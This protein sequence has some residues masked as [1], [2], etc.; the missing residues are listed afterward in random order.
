M[1]NLHGRERLGRALEPVGRGLARTGITPDAITVVG[2][3]GVSGGALGFF[4]R[5]S[6]FVGTLVVT[7]F[8]FSDMLD[9]ALARALGT[10]GPWGAFLDS[11]MDRI[12]DAAVFGSFVIWYAGRGHS[13]PLAGA[14]LASLAG[15]FVTS[16]AKARAESLGFTCNVGFA[17]RAER[18]II[19]LVAAGFYGLGVPYLL[20]VALWF[21]AGA[22]AVTAGQ[23]LVAVHRQATAT[24]EPT[25]TAPA[26]A[27]R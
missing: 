4:T 14:A 27:L 8:V 22:T 24:P 21:L 15:G 16:Y 23:R 2:T 10:S 12:G 13:L 6:F 3:I 1:L 5:G 25:P 26:S 7:A 20:P 19:V 17:E 9:G 11:A 18:L